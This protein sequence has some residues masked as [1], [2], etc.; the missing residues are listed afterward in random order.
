[1]K[2]EIYSPGSFLRK[3]ILFLLSAPIF[4]LGAELGTVAFALELDPFPDYS[5]SRDTASFSFHREE[6]PSFYWVN[7]GVPD[8]FFKGVLQYVLGPTPNPTVFSIRSIEYGA[9]VDGWLTDQLQ[10]RA[11]IPFEANAMLDANGNTQNVSKFGDLEVGATYLLTGKREN[12][13]FIGVD[14]WYRFATGTNPFNMDFPLLST[15]RG[16][17]GEAIGLILGQEL[18]GFSFFQSVHYEKTQPITVDSSN[19]LFGAGVFQWPDYFHATARIDYLLFHRAQRFV[20]LFYE[21]RM[22][23]SGLMEF[24]HQAV[25]YGLSSPYGVGPTT[26]TTDLLF[27]SSGGLEIRVD[28]EFTA[29]GKVTWIPFET[30]FTTGE[31]RP[32]YGLLFSFDLTFR[33]I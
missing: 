1:M 5:F 11:A 32:D 2:K 7:I 28:K 10:L 4:F 29:Q 30:F 13:N 23:E 21:L 12:G 20:R 19:N 8:L 18:G 16:A 33:P 25:T 15:G 14:G 3:K 26:A 9:K 27:F 17:P 24:N 6:K 22:R 31:F